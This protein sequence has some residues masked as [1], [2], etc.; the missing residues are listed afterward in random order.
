MAF[1]NEHG[2]QTLWTK[3]KSNTASQI[4]EN[5]KTINNA[6][7]AVDA[8]IPTVL[9]SPN[10][11]TIKGN[12]TAV[13]TYTGSAAGE[14]NVVPGSNIKVEAKDGEIKISAVLT[15][16]TVEKAELADKATEA[17]HADQATNANYAAS[18][19]EAGHA[20]SADYATDAG[21]AANADEAEH[22]DTA[23]VANKVSSSLKIKLNGG[24]AEGTSQFTYD[25]SAAKEVNITPA[26]IGTNTK[27]EFEALSA[28]VDKKLEPKDLTDYA[29]KTYVDTAEADAI[30]TAKGYTNE[31]IALLLD[32][33]DASIN[34]I[35]ELNDAIKENDDAINALGEIADARALKSTKVI[36]GAGLSGGGDLSNDITITNAGV[37]SI[38]TGSADGTISVN[39]N[40]TSADVAVKGL[41]SAAYKPSTDFAPSSL[42][43]T[44]TNLST[45]VNTINGAYVKEFEFKMANATKTDGTDIASATIAGNKATITLYAIPDSFITNLQ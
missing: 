4:T 33:P 44:V 3:I 21:H 22:A 15:G 26:A 5:N 9:P 7:N 2:V 13:E 14:V 6:I 32:N 34:S 30:N 16:V 19:G 17:D 45:T 28:K 27:E 29:T 23:D 12:G 42:S 18:A 25:G 37:R 10:A 36:A 41:G 1:L 43:N 11:L 35:K 20:A 31:Q 40:G 8:K 24:T 39:T 38:A